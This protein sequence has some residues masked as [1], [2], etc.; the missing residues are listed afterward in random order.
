MEPYVDTFPLVQLNELCILLYIQ[1][2]ATCW[3]TKDGMTEYIHSDTSFA[4][5]D[6][7]NTRIHYED[8]ISCKTV[9]IPKEYFQI[10][11]AMPIAKDMPYFEAMWFHTNN[12][13][14]RKS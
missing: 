8:Y 12:L 3:Q 5:M 9:D 1:I 13:K 7:Y 11:Y 2:S 6:N 14:V 4:M 10:Q